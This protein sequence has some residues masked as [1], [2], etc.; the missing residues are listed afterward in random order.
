MLLDVLWA[1]ARPALFSMDAERAHRL[2]IESLRD[3]PALSRGLIESLSSPTD[4]A[5][6]VDL[7]PLR[8]ASP[9]GLAAG[10]DKDGEAIEIWPSLGFGFIEVG[11]VT[12][13]PQ[14]GNPQP[15]LFRLKRERALI[16][17]MGFNN[18]GSQALAA[19]LTA[20]H[21]GG[22]WPQVP[23]GANIGKS[24]ITPLDEATED[25]LT[26]VRRLN[27]LVDYFTVNVS[28]P[29]TPGLRELQSA[30][31]LSELLGAVVPA[32]QAPV[33]VKISPDLADED[34]DA[35]VEVAYQSGCVA[36]IATNTT[37]SRPGT[38]DRIGEGGGMSG[39]P[40]WPLARRRIRRAVSV[41]GGRI[42]IVGVGGVRSA[43]QA[44]ALLDDGCVAVQLYSGLI[45]EGPGLIGRINRG[46][47]I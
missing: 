46:L 4:P 37:S 31:R 19:T 14:D 21:D 12:A 41:A 16:N 7:G 20:L 6:A 36:L 34:L 3:H 43:V 9:I 44:Q 15:R 38:T 40:L 17:R 18:K 11:T 13:H 29:N 1:A 26:S 22:F 10:L 5:L 30:E 42:P 28:S 39:A 33:M 27:G 45:F 23:V 47:R 24:K 32:A 25:Y 35:A 8:L 2:T